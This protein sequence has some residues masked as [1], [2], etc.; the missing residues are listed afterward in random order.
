MKKLLI[1]LS[2]F[3]SPLVAMEGDQQRREY[4]DPIARLSLHPVHKMNE[5]GNQRHVRLPYM[6]RLLGD[7]LAENWEEFQEAA[8]D[9][10]D[11]PA[12]K[13][14]ALFKKIAEDSEPLIAKMA[15]NMVADFLIGQEC[16]T[17][18]KRKEMVRGL[19]VEDGGEIQC[20]VKVQLERIAGILSMARKVHV[21]EQES[22]S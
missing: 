22:K 5:M 2:L 16:D 17:D 11:A 1:V 21:A 15:K 12:T 20:S 7:V 8:K 4:A 13:Y 18:S 10:C 6:D 3:V 19:L 9:Y 14:E